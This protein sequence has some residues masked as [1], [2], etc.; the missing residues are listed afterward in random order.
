MW[1]I[2]LQGT[3][4]D[5]LCKTIKCL[6]TSALQYWSGLCVNLQRDIS[7]SPHAA[8]I[9]AWTWINHADLLHSSCRMITRPNGSESKS[10]G[11]YFRYLCSYWGY[12]D[13]KTG[14]QLADLMGNRM[15]PVGHMVLIIANVGIHMEWIMCHVYLILK[16]MAYHAPL[17]VEFGIKQ[18]PSVLWRDI[19]TCSNLYTRFLIMNHDRF[20]TQ[21]HSVTITK[22][23]YLMTKTAERSEQIFLTKMAIG[24][25][26]IGGWFPGGL[27]RELAYQGT[28][29]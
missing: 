22:P 16:P 1:E 29:N 12:V 20:R 8:D 5:A 4:G 21:V 25:S 2:F 15:S 18:N 28:S 6:T 27:L 26:T 3:A 24:C 7:F 13:E 10:W 23:E 11:E 14:V 17:V 9:V 19:T